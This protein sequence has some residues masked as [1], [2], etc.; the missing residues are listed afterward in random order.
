MSQAKISRSENGATATLTCDDLELSNDD[1][2]APGGEPQPAIFEARAVL[3]AVH[4]GGHAATWTVTSTISTTP[5]TSRQPWP[6]P[7][8]EVTQ[9]ALG[10]IGLIGAVERGYEASATGGPAGGTAGPSRYRR[11]QPPAMP[12][13]QSPGIM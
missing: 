10:A 12:C 3:D 7:A 1:R 4:P 13:T 9:T 8:G 2:P 5:R 11:G 6:P